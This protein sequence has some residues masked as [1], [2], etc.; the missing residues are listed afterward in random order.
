MFVDPFYTDCELGTLLLLCRELLAP[1]RELDAE[2]Y[3]K[4]Y[5]T[6]VLSQEVRRK[7]LFEGKHSPRHQVFGLYR[8]QVSIWVREW[9]LERWEESTQV[10][11]KDDLPKLKALCHADRQRLDAVAEN[12][13]VNGVEDDS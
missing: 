13:D 12:G 7:T 9:A 10:S 4:T 3:T 1:H 5:T 6:R 8:V 2:L 11:L